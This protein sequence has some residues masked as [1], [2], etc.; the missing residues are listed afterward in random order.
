MAIFAVNGLADA[1]QLAVRNLLE[2]G[3]GVTVAGALIFYLSR[4]NSREAFRGDG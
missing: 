2:G 3:I 4:P 1:A